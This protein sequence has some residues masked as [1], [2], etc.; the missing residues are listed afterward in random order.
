MTTSIL[1]QD[2]LTGNGPCPHRGNHLRASK[3]EMIDVLFGKLSG[4]LTPNT[5]MISLRVVISNRP[6]Y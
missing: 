1:G 5:R 4:C 6:A 3:C 2:A